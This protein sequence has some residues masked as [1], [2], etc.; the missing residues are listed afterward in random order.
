MLGVSLQY[1]LTFT[2]V[3]TLLDLGGIPL[4]AI[5]RAEDATL[6]LVGG[7]TASHPEPVAPFIDAAFIGEAEERA[8]RGR[9]RVGGAAR[10]RSAP[11]R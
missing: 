2:N 7:P 11:A 5:D 1:E 6:V 9:A 4:R 8:R 3:L 10:A